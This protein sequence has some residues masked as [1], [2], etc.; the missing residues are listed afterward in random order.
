MYGTKLPEKAAKILQLLKY[1][2]N[3]IRTELNIKIHIDRYSF[4]N[5]A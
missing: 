4:S 3:M 2:I 1:A 5:K